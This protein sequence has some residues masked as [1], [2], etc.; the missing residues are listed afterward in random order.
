MSDGFYNFAGVTLA[1]F[2]ALLLGINL[3]DATHNT[4]DDEVCVQYSV[5]SGEC[6]QTSTVQELIDNAKEN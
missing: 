2:L 4:L 6:E 1:I 3:E 5:T